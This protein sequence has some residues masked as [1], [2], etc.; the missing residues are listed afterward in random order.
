MSE[1]ERLWRGTE[2]V[3][4]LKKRGGSYSDLFGDELDGIEHRLLLGMLDPVD[5]ST[6]EIAYYGVFGETFDEALMRPRGDCAAEL[7]H[8]D[9][10]GSVPQVQPSAQAQAGPLPIGHD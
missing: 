7:R 10:Q 8:G 1:T 2:M 4:A 6:L 9:A 5:E 3:A